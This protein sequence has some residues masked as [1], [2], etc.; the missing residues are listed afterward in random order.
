DPD[1]TRAT[2]ASVLAAARREY[3]IDKIDEPRGLPGAAQRAVAE[4]AANDGVVVAAGG[5]GTI[6]AVARAALGRRCAFGVIPQG[7]FN[8]FSRCHG[9]PLDTVEATRLLLSAY[10]HPVQVGLVN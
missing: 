7:T 10:P 4:A 5:D 8:Y 9:I 1:S 6:N 3:R 2:I